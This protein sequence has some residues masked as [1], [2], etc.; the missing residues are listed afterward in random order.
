M[1]TS[2]FSSHI[3]VRQTL[4]ASPLPQRLSQEISLP[5]P[6]K[7]IVLLNHPSLSPGLKLPGPQLV[8]SSQGIAS[9]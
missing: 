8:P 6:L 7:A 9:V 1:A 5:F 2:L 3:W 4:E